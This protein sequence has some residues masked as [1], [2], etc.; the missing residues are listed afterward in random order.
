MTMLKNYRK[1]LTMHNLSLVSWLSISA[2]ICFATLFPY[3][4]VGYAVTPLFFYEEPLTALFFMFL[5]LWGI[6]SFQ[7]IISIN[8][9]NFLLIILL[10][11]FVCFFPFFQMIDFNASGK[12]ISSL[13][14]EVKKVLVNGE[15]VS[16]TLG[17]KH[18]RLQPKDRTSGNDFSPYTYGEIS[19]II[20]YLKENQR[21]KL[22]ALDK[23]KKDTDS[24]REQQK[25]LL[26]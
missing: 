10:S 18:C 20:S 22:I 3:S 17:E 25:A 8:D 12:Y 21:D 16:C 6:Y 13:S 1:I 11:G 9:D 14:P 2:V 15:K 4:E 19:R 5:F 7:G 26:E 24:A 23:I